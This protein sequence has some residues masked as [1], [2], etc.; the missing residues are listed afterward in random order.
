[1]DTKRLEY[2]FNCFISKKSSFEEEKELMDLVDRSESEEQV[3]RIID[4]FFENKSMEQQMPQNISGTILNKILQKEEAVIVPFEN[5]RLYRMGWMKIAS[6]ILFV[7]AAYIYV[8]YSDEAKVNRPQIAVTKKPLP[9]TP[10]NHTV[11]TMADGTKILLD[12]LENGAIQHGNLSISKKNG[13]VVFNAS[14]SNASESL[15]YNTLS[16]PRGGQYK[17]I[18]ADGSEVWLNASSSL[19][20]PTSFKGN[21]REVE[22]KGEGYFEVAKNKA[23]PFYVSVDDMMIK[24]LGTH[25]NVNAYSDD[26]TIKT[27]LLEGSVKITRGKA[28]GLLKPGEQGIVTKDKGKVEIKEVNVSEVMA[29]K[30]GL[31]QFDG[32]DIVTIMNQISRWYDVDI[33]YSGKVPVRHFQGKISRDAALSQVLKILELSN[34]KFKMEGKK[35]IV[36]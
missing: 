2:L 31:F 9:F 22:L 29:W 19:R 17:V 5:K 35:I 7:F 26:N 24:V 13:L 27:S 20:F 11:L 1:M 3:K 12:S 8:T 25:F 6:V 10:G 34:V 21:K 15:S 33:V 18:L 4:R 28:E 36:D 14:S 23:K 30:N 16:T 32:A